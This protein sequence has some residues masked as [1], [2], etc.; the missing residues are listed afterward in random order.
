MIF[1]KYDKKRAQEL[2]FGL[3]LYIDMAKVGVAFPDFIS[4]EKPR[5]QK[6]YDIRGHSTRDLFLVLIAILFLTLLFLKIFSLQIIEGNRYRFLSNNNR[7]R[8]VVVHAPRGVVLDRNGE[9]LVFNVPGF[10]KIEKGKVKLLS[11]N[12]ALQAIAEGEK[13]LDFDSFRKYPYTDNFAHALGYVGEISEEELKDSRFSGYKGGD[14][15]GKMGIEKYYEDTLKGT[16]GKQLVEVD[17]RG[18]T[19]RKLGQT[20]PIPGFNITLNLDLNLQ[21]AAS[22]ALKNTQKGA[23]VVST[24]KGEVLTLISKP[25]FDP[26]LFTLPAKLQSAGDFAK[27]LDNVLFDLKG[28]PLLNRAVSGTYPPGSTFKLIVAAAGLENKMID[29]NFT[30]QDTGIISVGAFSFSN[31]YF[32]GYGK[33]EGT[34]NVVKGIK[35]STDTFFYKLAEIVGVGKISET[36]EKFGLGKK[37]GIDLSG[38]KGGIVPTP[39]WK[40]KEI[41]EPW[42]LG[43]TY[44]YGIGQGYL[45]TTPLQVNGWT[46]ALANGGVLYEPHL[47]KNQKSKIS[48]R[49][50]GIAH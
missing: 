37:L 14:F 38:E 16:D 48:F 47:L 10:R 23:V 43:D 13:D 29:E 28:Q 33:T 34:V 46:Q 9:S 35:R 36:A 18:K 39:S 15:V 50:N 21:K 44:H 26:N 11:T 3:F 20:D 45:L 27:K 17:S 32:T 1:L 8:T 7:I 12:E 40:E 42:Y 41:G 6:S 49:E 2:S 4:S 24:P 22:D 19:I 5:R 25:S 31:W 30:I